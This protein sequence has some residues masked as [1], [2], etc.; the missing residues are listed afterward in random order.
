MYLLHTVLYLQHW[1]LYRN[2]P[3]LDLIVSLY[4]QLLHR[5]RR[6]ARHSPTLAV[7]TAR[8]VL[9]KGRYCLPRTLPIQYGPRIPFNLRTVNM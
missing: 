4:F 8:K 6:S 3:A 9:F 1:V 7:I 5:L 2:L